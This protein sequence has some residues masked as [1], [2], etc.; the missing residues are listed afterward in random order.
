MLKRHEI[1]ISGYYQPVATNTEIAQI[2][3]TLA[4]LMEL[5]GVNKFRFIALQKA[6]RRVSEAGFSITERAAAGTLTDIPDIGEKIAAKIEEIVA[7]GRLGELE[8][9]FQKYPPAL[10][11]ME[12]VQGVGPRTA[13]RVWEDLGVSNIAELE[14]AARD[15]SIAGLPGL[16]EKSA[17][18]IL[19]A[20]ERLKVRSDRLLLGEVL[21]VAEEIAERLRRV[22]GARNVTCAGSV[23]RMKETVKDVDIIATATDPEALTGAVGRLPMVADIITSGPTKCSVRT[24]AGLQVDLRVVPDSLYGNLLQHFTGSKEH[25]IALRELAISMGLKVSE[26]GVEETA[27]GKVNEC[28][29]EAEVYSLLGLAYIPP[30]LR[31]DSGELKAA[32]EGRLPHLIE[33]GDLKGDLHLHTDWSDGRA[34]IKEMALAALDRGYSYIGVSDHTQSMGMVRG[35]TPKRLEEQLAEI[36]QVNDE[37]EGFRVFASAEVDVRSDGSLDL[38]DESL[39]SLDFVTVSIH[40]GFNQEK[41]QIMERLRAAMENPFVRAIGHPTGRLINRREPYEVDME[42][43]IATAA[44]T[45]TALEINSHFQR[46]DL[47]D[48]HARAAKNASVP[49]VINSDAHRPEHL[50]VLRYGIATARR[51]WIEPA[52]VLNTLSTS[53]MEKVL[54]KPKTGIL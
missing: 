32:A 18:N 24:H 13:R 2:L 11:E 5:D 42:E 10:I 45:G 4:E 8:E 29:T 22:P 36:A 37:L 7:T 17:E 30:E 26:Y 54:L 53:A 28:A 27:S 49:L 34:S 38:P 41:S 40:S 19:K 20:I 9:Y 23:R 21:P 47:N 39:S 43:I 50:D 31:E 33:T 52:D 35:L 25:N 51:G 44:R 3:E 15:G 14:A 46:L 12:R 16:G 1:F 48:I 6:A